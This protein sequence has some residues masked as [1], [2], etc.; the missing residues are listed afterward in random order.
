MKKRK[1][2][3][4]C[5]S[6]LIIY[7][8]SDP[9]QVFAEV[10]DFG[11]PVKVFAGGYCLIGGNWIAR[12]EAGPAHADR[13]PY[14]TVVR[15]FREEFTL[16]RTKVDPGECA[17]LGIA[18]NVEAY[19]TSLDREPTEEDSARLDFL[20]DRIITKIIH[21]RSAIIEVPADVFL[22]AD[23]GYSKGGYTIL[24]SYFYAGLGEESWAELMYL[25]EKY[26]NLSNE[27]LTTVLTLNRLF[28][29]KP[30]GT[31]GHDQALQ[32][33]FMDFDMEA[34]A[35]PIVLGITAIEVVS[36]PGDYQG[37]LERFEV[38]NYPR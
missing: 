33:F 31:W 17:K 4:H 22:K 3:S 9:S 27:S 36:A 28:D 26:G 16:K 38:E 6:V 1:K 21:Y 30:L 7:R 20:R 34:E 2:V 24:T 35:M 13:S 11:Y 18:D 15:E 12:N 5:S 25:Q 29:G 14:D 23:P 10:K 37:I 19:T 8:L 32:A